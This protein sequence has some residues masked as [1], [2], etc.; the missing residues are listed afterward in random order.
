[1]SPTLLHYSVIWLPMLFFL[2]SMSPPFCPSSYSVTSLLTFPWFDTFFS[3][4]SPTFAPS[5]YFSPSSLFSCRYS[6]VGLPL[7]SKLVCLNNYWMLAMLKGWL[8]NDVWEWICINS[9]KCYWKTLVEDYC[10][11]RITIRFHTLIMIS[12]SVLILITLGIVSLFTLASSSGYIS[13]LCN[14]SPVSLSC[15]LCYN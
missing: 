3:S 15:T 1:M 5:L 4:S 2:F 8:L 11:G 6:R 12:S 7:W 9:H 10:I 13:T 14:P